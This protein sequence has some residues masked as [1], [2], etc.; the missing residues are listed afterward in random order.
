MQAKQAMPK[1]RALARR[2][3]KPDF[4]LASSRRCCSAASLNCE[5]WVGAMVPVGE[6]VGLELGDLDAERTTAVYIKAS[7]RVAR[8]PENRIQAKSQMA[9]TGVKSRDV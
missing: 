1:T 6:R 3:A 2:R 8:V 7:M 9:E 4:L 5:A